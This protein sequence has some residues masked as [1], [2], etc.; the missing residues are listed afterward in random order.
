V[1]PLEQ[2]HRSHKST[3][4]LINNNKKPAF[5]LGGRNDPKF[6]HPLRPFVFI[7]C[8][9]FIH[10]PSVHHSTHSTAQGKGVVKA[11]LIRL[12][13]FKRITP[14]NFNKVTQDE[15]EVDVIFVQPLLWATQFVPKC[16][17]SRKLM[18]RIQQ[19]LIQ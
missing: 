1:A 12:D 9:I 2:A 17:T 4:V 7:H 5:R 18:A 6:I 19:I 15:E 13:E 11:D 8:H 14:E 3:K 16:A 10:S